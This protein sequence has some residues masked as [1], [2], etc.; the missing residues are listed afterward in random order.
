MREQINYFQFGKNTDDNNTLRQILL[1]KGFTDT[2]FYF[3]KDCLRVNIEG[4]ELSAE[5][6]TPIVVSTTDFYALKYKETCLANT[7][8]TPE[9][10][11]YRVRRE[12]F[13]PLP[14]SSFPSESSMTINF[15]NI[16]QLPDRLV[17]FDNH[18][19]NLFLIR[20]RAHLEHDRA[21]FFGFF[22]RTNVDL[23]MSTPEIILH[24]LQADNR[25][26]KVCIELGWITRQGAIA[27]SAPGYI[28]NIS[29]Q[30]DGHQCVPC[31]T[32]H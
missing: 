31:L 12:N 25:S 29:A 20:H 6:T 4:T 19:K 15:H 17:D 24:A 23:T 16:N 26:R 1:D 9:Y 13:A 18:Y 11:V 30:R 14:A 28:K 2:Q 32:G 3:F 21:G 5:L 7:E 27:A 22:R 8:Y 10:K